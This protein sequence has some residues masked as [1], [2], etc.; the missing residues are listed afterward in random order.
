MRD[1]YNKSVF[2][3]STGRFSDKGGCGSRLLHRGTG[4]SGRMGSHTGR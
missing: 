4:R 3:C 1:F 2:G